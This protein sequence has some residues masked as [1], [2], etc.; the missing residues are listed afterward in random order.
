VETKKIP[1]ENEWQ[2]AFKLGIKIPSEKVEAI[3]L[4]KAK[5]RLTDFPEVWSIRITKLFEDKEDFKND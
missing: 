5:S 2:R 4:A 1:N 3:Q